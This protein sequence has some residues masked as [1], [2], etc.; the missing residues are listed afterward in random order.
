MCQPGIPAAATRSSRG[1]IRTLTILGLPTYLLAAP[2]ARWARKEY[3]E[4]CRE[5]R[6]RTADL[7]ST[8]RDEVRLPLFNTLRRRFKAAS[9]GRSTAYQM[10][11]V[12]QV[13]KLP[14]SLRQFLRGKQ[15]IFILCNHYFNV[16]IVEALQRTLRR[17]LKFALE[18]H[19]IQSRHYR[20][21][22][23]PMSDEAY[24]AMLADE[25]SFVAKADRLIHI[26][27]EEHAFFAA[28]LP[29]RVHQIVYPTILE[30]RPV[31]AAHCKTT[32]L[33]VAAPNPPNAHSVEWFLS[34]VWERYRGNGSLRIVGGI[35]HLMGHLYPDTLQRWQ[36]LFAGRVEDIDAEY[37]EA[38]VVVVP[39][40]SGEGI[41]IKF[42]EAMAHGKPVL[43][44]PHAVRGAAGKLHCLS[45][46]R[47]L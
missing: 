23:T 4:Y 16:P 14:R 36:P 9:A 13:T 31:T 37:A 42:A 41:S 11:E 34:E 17:P 3:N 15:E 20:Q 38:A 19:D 6:L 32:F 39:A 43:F 24:Q 30:R 28:A 26:N 1:Q 47:A 2:G 25:I 29:D 12:A 45:A 44:T 33:I 18:T 10:T 21:R 8:A 40:I 7:Q 5:Y 22:E 27:P 35:D 46:F